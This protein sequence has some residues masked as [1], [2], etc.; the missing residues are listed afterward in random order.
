MFSWG[1]QALQ[2]ALSS[3]ENNSTEKYRMSGRVSNIYARKKFP[4]SRQCMAINYNQNTLTVGAPH[5]KRASFRNAD[6][7]PVFGIFLG[8]TC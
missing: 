5:V 4:P 3:K 1:S 2:P 7:S 8:L 6:F